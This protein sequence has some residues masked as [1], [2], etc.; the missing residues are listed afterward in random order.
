[1]DADEETVGFDLL[2]VRY[3]LLKQFSSGKLARHLRV[4]AVY[5]F[6]PVRLT[7]IDN[8]RGFGFKQ[9]LELVDRSGKAM[10]PD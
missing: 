3:P 1:M 7:L 8:S 4:A 6:R 2:V 10:D 5:L 9:T